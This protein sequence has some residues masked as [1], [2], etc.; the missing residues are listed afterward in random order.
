MQTDKWSCLA[1]P[2]TPDPSVKYDT[3][4]YLLT[5]VMDGVFINLCGI[6]V[7]VFMN[8]CLYIYAVG[9]TEHRLH[10]CGLSCASGP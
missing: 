4:L 3:V 8:W 10:S 2:V 6:I 5:G 7:A 9:V 1:P